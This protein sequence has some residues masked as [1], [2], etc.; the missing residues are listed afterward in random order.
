M[1]T[2]SRI[3]VQ[4]AAQVAALLAPVAV[5]AAGD[6]ASVAEGERL[7]RG[8]CAACHATRE[9]G[10][11]D[12]AALAA[13]PGPDLTTAGSRFRGEWLAQWLVDPERFRPAGFVP[14]RHTVITADGDK[15]DRESLAAHPALDA[16]SAA[17]VA[18]YLASQ[19]AAE[20]PYPIAEP[21]A[22]IRADVQFHKILPCGACHRSTDGRGGVSAPDLSA[23]S[24]RLRPEWL[25]SITWDPRSR[26]SVLMPRAPLR[27]DQLATLAAYLDTPRTESN[28]QDLPYLAPSEEATIPPPPNGPAETIYRM[29]CST[30]HGLAGNGRGINSSFLFISPRDH[31][32]FEE[33]SRLSDEAIATAIER[34]GAAVGKSALMPAWGSILEKEEIDLLVAY[35]RRLSGSGGGRK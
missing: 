7:F 30:C 15:I 1:K 11:S 29:L 33:M 16:A 12:W 2:M 14:S 9:A 34:G 5:G 19:R 8:Q 22:A 13:L 6:A 35:L 21:S 26:G 17:A 28:G 18:E 24:R 20:V 10:A 31:T 4:V 32:S 27:A 3:A 25:R 23:A